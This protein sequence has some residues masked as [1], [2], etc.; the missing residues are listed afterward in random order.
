MRAAQ[1]AQHVVD[2]LAP[3]ETCKWPILS[4]A[5][6]P[7]EMSL[8]LTERSNYGKYIELPTLE[9]AENLALLRHG[10]FK[11]AHADALS[12][13]WQPT[14]STLR[15]AGDIYIS[16]YM[17]MLIGNNR[18]AY[19]ITPDKGLICIALD[20]FEIVMPRLAKKYS[21]YRCLLS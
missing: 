19:T 11:A 9:D 16:D 12:P 3:L 17:T 18:L 21:I 20:R 14:E 13:F 15:R 6:I 2:K 10:T 5:T 4:C 8:A 1:A 7:H